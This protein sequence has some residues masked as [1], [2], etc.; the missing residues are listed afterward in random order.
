MLV[1]RGGADNPLS[2]Q[3]SV[4]TL[5]LVLSRT[6]RHGARRTSDRLIAE[7][8]AP[9]RPSGPTTEREDSWR[10]R[11]S[12]SW[13]R[14]DGEV[15]E[16]SVEEVRAPCRP[17]RGADAARRA[18]E[19]GVPRRPPRRRGLAAARL[20]RDARR[21]DGPRQADADHRLLRRRHALADRGA[22]AEGDGLH[23]RRLDDRRLHGVEERRHAVHAG[24]SVHATSS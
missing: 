24:P 19:G 12:R 10:R 15:P 8:R 5:V 23:Q 2:S 18:R 14:P 22:H 11:T 4:A 3:W 16:V 1:L 17:T 9:S 21:G 6:S 7:L 13:T 20:P